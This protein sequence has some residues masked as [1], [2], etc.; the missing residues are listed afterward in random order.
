MNKESFK[1]P[2]GKFRMNTIQHSWPEQSGILADA[3][4]A[5]GYGGTATNP[6]H[7]NGFT[8]NQE[9]LMTFRDVLKELRDRDMDYWIYDELGYPSGQGGGL[10][11]EGHPELES[12]GFYMRRRL[13]YEPRHTV[14][15]LDDESDRIVWAA[16]Y[17]MDCS[18][19]NASVVQFEKMEKIP[20]TDTH[21]EC[22]LDKNEIMYVFCTKPAYEGAHLTHNVSSKRRY[23]NI[24]DEKAVRRFLDVAYEPIHEADPTAY[25]GAGAVFTDEPSLQVAY[26]H[27]DESWPYALAPWVDDLFEKF[28]EEY[29]YSLIP[30]LPQIFEG[31]RNA[32]TTRIRFYELVGKIIAKSY[33]AQIADW[34]REHGTCFSGHYLA[35]ESMLAHVLYYGSYPA[36]LKAA[37]YPGVDVLAAY[38]DIYHHNTT[39]FAQMVSR[40][41]QMNGIM[42]EL[43]P[44]INLDHF[45][46]KPVQY[47]AG[48]LSLLY[49]GGCRKINSYFRADFA[50]YNPEILA[51]YEG[52]MN[53][54]QAI[55]V[56]EYV[57][58]LGTML[59][60]VSNDCGTFVY[61]AVEDVQA[62]T[63][64]SNFELESTSSPTDMSLFEVTRK[65]YNSGYDYLIADKDDF[66]E[67]AETM[68]EN[69][70]YISGIKVKN[71]IVPAMDII[72][73]ETWNALI[74]M[75]AAGVNV[76]FADKVPQYKVG[77]ELPFMYYNFREEAVLPVH[78][79]DG[80][81]F[82]AMTADQILKKIEEQPEEFRA[83]TMQ[84]ERLMTAR[85]VK[86]GR[87]IYYVI[88]KSEE[89]A[90]VKWTCEGK[91]EIEVWDP[92]DGTVEV[93]K[94]GETVRLNACYG[95]FFVI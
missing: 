70:A 68:D 77:E 11:L 10:S 6:P 35:E 64:P 15:D 75:Q 18:V 31:G 9:N 2:A 14:F 73:P 38:P 78:N 43:C 12:R 89:N 85:F 84:G 93:K 67:V 91:K 82:T 24:M 44:F 22:D 23:I 71:V 88:N 61:Y 63:R 20:F 55:W 52:F 92:A 62:K 60:Q 1:N 56:N 94:E 65:L 86:A 4:K 49:F 45:E 81:H 79:T 37:G 28:E 34:C 7:R 29:G 90:D 59:D 76:F 39:R 58:R 27:G 50:S 21:C 36:V 57:G 40:K 33:V 74:K 47:S 87:V 26:M 95:I 72:Y 3:I 17:P 16:K 48:I 8:G 42:V 54:E 19:I 46:K 51:P 83:E 80:T 32:Y 13:A 53:Q 41:N 25:P 66:A 30:Y 5:F 69:G